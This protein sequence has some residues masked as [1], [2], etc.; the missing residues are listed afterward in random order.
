MTIC[1]ADENFCPIIIKKKEEG[2]HKTG[3]KLSLEDDLSYFVNY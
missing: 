2:K 1:R 3:F